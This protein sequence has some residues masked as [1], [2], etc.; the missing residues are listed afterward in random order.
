MSDRRIYVASLSDYNAGRLHGVWIDVDGKDAN[1]L[2]DEVKAML[3]ESKEE[4][5]EEYAIHDH[6]GFGSVLG[7]FTPLSEVAELAELLE[8][9]GDAYLAYL[10]YQDVGYASEEDFRE[11]Y[12]GEWDS[13][14]AW[15]E[16]WLENTGTLDSIPEDLRC[17]FDVEKWVH[18]CELN[19]EI[20][21]VRY[22][23]ALYAFRNY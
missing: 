16:D 21:F 2:Y 8:K 7:E 15:G 18:D 14:E 13:K 23:G 19:S 22:G 4:I 5:A 12:A 6:E 11:R 1:Q 10:E 20:R 17:Y 3:A 9:H